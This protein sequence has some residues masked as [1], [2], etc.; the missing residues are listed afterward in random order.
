MTLN[1]KDLTSK[2]TPNSIRMLLEAQQQTLELLQK[3]IKVSK[4]LKI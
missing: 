3:I 2:T 1:K 4:A